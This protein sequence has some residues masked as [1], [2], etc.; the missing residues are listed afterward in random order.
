MNYE[1][2][3]PVE[4]EVRGLMQ[5]HAAVGQLGYLGM[6]VSDPAAWKE[7]SENVLGLQHCRTLSNGTLQFRM[8]ER[9]Q[10][11]SLMPAS[12]DQLTFAGWE[13]RDEVTMLSIAAKARAAGASVEIGDEKD[14]LDRQTLGLV[15]FQDPDGFTIE[16]F[17]GAFNSHVPFVSPL[18]VSFVAGEL[19]IG[20][21]VLRVTDLETSLRFYQEVLGVRMSDY[22]VLT[23]DGRAHPIAFT[24]INRR[25]HSLAL[26]AGLTPSI[27]AS[28]GRLSHFMVEPSS[29]DDV[30]RAFDRV[31]ERGLTHGSLGRHTNDRMLSF[32]T[33]TPSG[34]N[35]EYGCQGITIDDPDNWVVRRYSSTT[36][37]GHEPLAIPAADSS[38]A[39][40]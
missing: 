6:S 40:R 8:D 10:R 27:L 37:W 35:V 19:G 18:G 9:Q 15:R 5:H 2:H 34:F 36:E 13:A 20:H 4:D 12:C 14:N 17:Y 39:G 11:L 1:G 38:I 32:Y 30:G 26:T 21:I 16:V 24:H 7:F 23:I 25:H 3:R 28:K 33:Q 22:I 29:L 31:K